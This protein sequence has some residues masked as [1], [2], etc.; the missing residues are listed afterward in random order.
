MGAKIPVLCRLCSKNNMDLIQVLERHVLCRTLD[1]QHFHF[2]S[3]YLKWGSRVCSHQSPPE[4]VECMVGLHSQHLHLAK[5]LYLR[6]LPFG[7]VCGSKNKTIIIN[8]HTHENDYFIMNI[9]E[10]QCM[11]LH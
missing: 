8:L 7:L 2:Q 10:R 9:S 5:L 6:S 3:C 11:S 1:L 4:A